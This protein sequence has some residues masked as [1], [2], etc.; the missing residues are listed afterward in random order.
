MKKILIAVVA[1]LL[2]LG[3]SGVFAKP[4]PFTV[5]TEPQETA[6]PCP[7]MELQKVMRKLWEEHLAYTR[8]YIISSLAGLGDSSVVADR[9]LKNQDDIGNAIK[10]YYGNTAGNE[11]ASLLRDHVVIA[12]EV[13]AAYK[14]GD[15]SVIHNAQLKWHANADAIADF[16]SGTNSNWSKN[17]MTELLYKHLDLTTDEIVYR[18]KNDWKTDIN[19]YDKDHDYIIMFAD[20][21]ADG[22]VKQFPYKF[23]LY[24]QM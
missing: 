18:L 21:L 12:I 17:E 16:L 5:L 22:I 8:N 19:F 23:L 24:K 4:K 2:V 14:G 3:C 20:A 6:R 10:P 11:L 15:S 7:P 9:W 1:L 13:V